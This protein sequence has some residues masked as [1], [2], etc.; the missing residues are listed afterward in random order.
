MMTTG[1]LPGFSI[2]CQAPLGTVTAPF[3]L[4]RRARPP[5]MTRGEP[6]I[7]TQCSARKR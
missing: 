1:A 4:S 3:G 7:T 6:A 5:T 2:R